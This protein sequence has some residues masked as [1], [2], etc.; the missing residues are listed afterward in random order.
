MQGLIW[1]TI[2]EIEKV[3]ELFENVKELSSNQNN[4]TISC[5]LFVWEDVLVL[6]CFFKVAV[7]NVLLI[8]A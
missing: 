3:N 6:F 1:F 2:E 7:I 4:A 8:A 5:H